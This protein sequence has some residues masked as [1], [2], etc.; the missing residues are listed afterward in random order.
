MTYEATLQVC[1]I[2]APT[3]LVDGMR[4][5]EIRSACQRLGHDVKTLHFERIRLDDDETTGIL[6]VE[7]TQKGA[8]GYR[9]VVYLWAGRIIE[10]KVDRQE[11]WEDPEQFLNH[12]GYRVGRLLVLTPKE[13]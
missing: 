1:S 7:Q 8:Q 11:L 5:Q 10:P 9:H 4:W 2:V 12:Y 13:D 3:V 6:E